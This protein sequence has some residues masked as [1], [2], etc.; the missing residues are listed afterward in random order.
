MSIYCKS[1]LATQNIQDDHRRISQARQ[2][3]AAQGPLPKIAQ[4]Q[5]V[6]FNPSELRKSKF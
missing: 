4:F 3:G 6:R 1:L 5:G 2:P